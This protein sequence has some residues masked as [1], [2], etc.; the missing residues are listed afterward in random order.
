MT[1]RFSSEFSVSHDESVAF[2]HLSGDHN[3][4]HV[5]PTTA[6]RLRF[7]DTVAHGIHLFLRSFDELAAQRLFDHQA[8]TALF[9]S[10]DNAVLTGAKVELD[11][12]ME[13]RKLRISAHVAG[14]RAFS[15]SIELGP[16]QR[17]EVTIED[18]EF[19][20]ACPE[21]VVFPPSPGDGAVPL[22]LSKHIF[23]TLFR[24]L[25]TVLGECWIADLL[26]TTQIVGMRC[27]GMHSIY[28]SFRLRRA[29]LP[30]R[31]ASMRYRVTGVET[32]LQMIR[33]QV[34]GAYLEGTIETFFRPPPVAQR[35]MNEVATLVSPSAFIGHRVLIVGGSRGLGELTAK[36]VAAGGAQVTLTYSRGREDAERICIEARH[37]GRDCTARHLDITNPRLGSV[38]E[39]LAGS[40]FS[41]VYFF[42]SPLIAKNTGSWSEALFQ[43]FTQIYVTAFATLV[44]HLR[45]RR[46]DPIA[47][48]RFLYPSSTFVNQ[49]ESGFCEYAV[50]KAAGEALCDQLQDR[51]LQFKKPRLPRMR[52][53][54]T[55]SLVDIGA[56]DPLPVMLEVACNMH[57]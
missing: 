21:E 55:S 24:S 35:S 6:R 25:N 37:L 2:A 23:G 46:A 3:P 50:A 8:P 56:V 49:V 29:S 7:G 33:V 31:I 51:N 19:S 16:L 36:I 43:Q 53:D 41:H 47:P 5:D 18:A 22:K 20:P 17:S 57:S 32:R 38:C 52:T 10:F 48:V 54:Q 12:Q 14:R 34:D 39:W 27:P 45:P 30:G 11:A 42:A 4:L 26:A 40:R 1:F 44:E 13:G 9:A 28:S 15:G